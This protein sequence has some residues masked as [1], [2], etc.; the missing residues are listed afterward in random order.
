MKGPSESQDPVRRPKKRAGAVKKWRMNELIF[1]F[2]RVVVPLKPAH[3]NGGREVVRQS[4]S[5]QWT[6]ERNPWKLRRLSDYL[7]VNLPRENQ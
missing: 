2:F 4:P 1:S 7:G 6:L 5:L 3:W